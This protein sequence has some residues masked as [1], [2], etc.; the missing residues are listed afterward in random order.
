MSRSL[1]WPVCTT[2]AFIVAIAAASLI[3]VAPA[4]ASEFCDV[5]NR[6]SA[7][8]KISDPEVRSRVE[9]EYGRSD[10]SDRLRT[11]NIE[12][13]C[14]DF[15]VAVPLWA[16]VSPPVMTHK[17]GDLFEDYSGATWEFVVGGDGAI[18]GVRMTA[19]DG[20]VTEME[21]LG[22]PRSFD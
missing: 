16:D 1:S 3:P 19:S 17:G 8:K 5:L 13:V 6:F 4:G 14:E 11:W 2:L 22:D 12:T 9:G 7:E 10:D 21:R 15:L 20:A 18:V